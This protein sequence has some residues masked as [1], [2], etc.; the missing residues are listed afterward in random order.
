MIPGPSLFKVPGPGAAD[1]LRR[2]TLV[3]HGFWW[4]LWLAGTLGALLL[5]GKLLVLG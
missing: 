1:N 3:P 5:G 4:L 2:R